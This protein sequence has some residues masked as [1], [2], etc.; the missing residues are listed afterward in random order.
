MT[1]AQQR[2]MLYLTRMY[3][4]HEGLQ[5]AEAI[6]RACRVGPRTLLVLERTGHIWKWDT[7]KW[8]IS[9]GTIREEGA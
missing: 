2:V 4:A 1:D 3:K 7:G 9:M 8:S 6:Y 5:D